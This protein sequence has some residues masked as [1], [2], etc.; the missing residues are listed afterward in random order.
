MTGTAMSASDLALRLGLRRIGARYE[1]TCPAC[2]Y[3]GFT[4]TTKGSQ[5]VVWCH[6]CRDREAVAMALAAR[7]GQEAEAPAPS[8]GPDAE[9][10]R[11]RAVVLWNSSAPA[12][13]T[14]VATYLQA[15][16]LPAALAGSDALRFRADCPHPG[17]GRLPAMVAS[18]TDQSG[19]IIGLHR[20]FLRRDG[21]G[22]A[23]VNP[24]KATIG[25]ISGG[26][27]RLAPAA[28]EL[29]LAEGIE[30]ALAAGLLTGL[31]AWS[32]LSAGN[33]GFRIALPRDVRAVVISVDRD[34]AGEKAARTATRRFKAEGRRV[35]LL[36][37]DAA[38][39][40][41]CDLLKPE[42]AHG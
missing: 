28:G 7:L 3:D 32:A 39:K 22:K 35:R 31:P 6:A 25:A 38:G 10:K 12:A 40:D 9:T 30:T 26:A 4:A 20:T 36:V 2:L 34:A 29:V 41:A 13:G 11:Q 17:G 23:D 42:V 37:P 27:V 24:A 21:S 16:G 19:T 15:R 1:G 8:R 14:I 5:A 18:I 33:L